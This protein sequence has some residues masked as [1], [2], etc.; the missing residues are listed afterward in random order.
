MKR[1]PWWYYPLALFVHQ[2]VAI[3][4]EIILHIACALNYMHQALSDEEVYQV[5]KMV[6]QN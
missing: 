2:G 1:T 5:R 6:L 4:T 3:V